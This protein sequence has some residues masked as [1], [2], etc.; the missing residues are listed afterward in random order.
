TLAVMAAT[1]IGAIRRRKLAL[2]VIA[3]EQ[4]KSSLEETNERFDTALENIAQGLA[5]FDAAGRLVVCNQRYR[6]MYRL[7]PDLAQPGR[8]V[9]ELLQHRAATDTY[10][11]NPEEYVRELL[12]VMACGKSLTKE[13]T[14]GDGRIVLVRSQPMPGGGWVAT[15]EDI[16]EAK[17]K[18]ASF[19]LLFENNPVPMWVFDRDSLRFL[20][21]NNAAVTAYGYSHEQFMAM[22][23][24]DVRPAEEREKFIEFFRTLPEVQRDERVGR[25]RKAD[26][27]TMIVSVFSQVLTYHNH[28]A[29]LVAI[30]D[31][32]QQQ[33]AED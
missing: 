1:I 14:T 19:R 7:P 8:L 5:M 27:T 11:G 6:E 10:L 30:H 33:L 18:E 17:Q 13:V 12:T 23:V 16:T 20:A 25:H 32:T 28:R 31:V 22:T 29:Q 26:G 3:L 9:L 2:T 4:S 21:V 15:H 24:L